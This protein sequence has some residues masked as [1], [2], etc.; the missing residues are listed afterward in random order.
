MNE[1]ILTLRPFQ[2]DEFRYLCAWFPNEQALVQW[3]G[4]DARFPLDCAQLWDMLREGEGDHPRRWLFSGL[5]GSDLIGHA[6]VALDWRHGVARLSRIAISPEFRGKRLS[7]PFLQKVLDHIFAH[8]EFERIELNVY[9]FNTTA[10][11]AYRKLGFVEE[12]VRRRSVK[13]GNAR[14]DTAIYGLLRDQI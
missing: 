9:T 5:R 2:E 14:W 11:S 10:I 3:G 13:V 8:P 1:V 6:Q 7:G 4:P 12:G